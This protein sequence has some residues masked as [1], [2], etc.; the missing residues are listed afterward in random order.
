[1]RR[2]HA[3][4][5]RHTRV[6][7]GCEEEYTAWRGRLTAALG[8]H[9]GFRHVEVHPPE[10][11]QPDWVTIEHF[12]SPEAARAWLRS[13]E[14]TRL[15]D[16]AR[17]FIEGLDSITIVTDDRDRRTDVT[18]VI[19]S[20]VRP[21]RERQFRQWLN[22]IQNAQATYPGYRRVSVQAPIPDV[23]PAWVTLLHF[24]TAEHLLGWLNSDECT[25]LTKES[26]EFIE[27]G[28]YRVAPTG[29]ANWLPPA[30]RAS[31]P[32]AWKINAIVLLTLYPLVM[33]TVL[34]L[35]PRIS[36]LG[37]GP[38]TF[39]GNVI[40]VAGTGFWL[41]PWAARRLGWWLDPPADREPGLT[42]AGVI[43]MLV[44]YGLLIAALSAL[45]VW[46]T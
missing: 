15:A 43:G 21:G 23:N 24:D 37:V 27:Q 2:D 16:Q 19:T 29:F 11:T 32:P 34:F 13:P 28:D 7:P 44:G 25:R 42:I 22:T 38:V 6:R 39:I 1:M 5:V 41:V 12:D 17:P 35:N 20:L 9:P 10:L 46:S 8:R 33:L 31:N 3:A 26:H 30:E 14:R 4:I 45:A 36:D 18:A 40:G